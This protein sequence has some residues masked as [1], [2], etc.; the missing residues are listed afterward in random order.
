MADKNPKI[1]ANYD[2]WK[3]KLKEFLAGYHKINEKGQK[4]FLYARLIT[5]VAHREQVNLISINNFF[6]GSQ[7]LNNKLMRNIFPFADQRDS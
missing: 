2:E 6:K 7:T 4:E 5:A 1:G 3:A